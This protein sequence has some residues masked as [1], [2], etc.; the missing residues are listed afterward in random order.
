M[1]KLILVALVAALPLAAGAADLIN[2][3]TADAMLLDTLPGI[4]AVKAQAIIDFRVAS[5]SFTS[6]EEIQNVSG[7]GP[8]TYTKL[9]P[10][11][12]VSGGI[13][14]LPPPP[15]PEP[16]KESSTIVQKVEPALTGQTN[17]AYEEETIRAPASAAI[18]AEAGAA[19]PPAQAQSVTALFS[20]PWLYGFIGLLVF[21]GATLLLL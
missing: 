9:A 18:A 10:L 7:I 2:I 19:I 6:I 4:G 12:T 11:I 16:K 5:G 17:M 1:K 21:S 3:N 14:T 8:A 15:K 20:S 13:S